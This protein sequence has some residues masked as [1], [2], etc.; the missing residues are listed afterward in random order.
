MC[1]VF[2]KDLGNQKLVLTTNLG[3]WKWRK[4]DVAIPAQT[5]CS[6]LSGRGSIKILTTPLLSAVWKTSLTFPPSTFGPLF[7]RVFGAID[8]PWGHLLFKELLRPLIF[9]G[10]NM[11]TFQFS[12][13]LTIRVLR[14]RYI[15]A[16][17]PPEP[18]IIHITMI[19]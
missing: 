3:G 17:I 18:N 9:L 16:A 13:C 14:T 11:A 15:T 7:A 6:L 12:F 1:Q 19:W 5:I 10:H 4:M 2:V 8:S